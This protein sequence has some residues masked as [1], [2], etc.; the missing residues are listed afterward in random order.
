MTGY[1]GFVGSRLLKT[2]VSSN[3]SVI[4]LGRKPVR[5][6]PFYSAD[7]A[8]EFNCREVLTGVDVVIH[9]AARVHVMQDQ[10]NDP[11]SQYRKINVE[12]T[13]SLA[14]Q[15]AELD[16][17]RFVFLS[18]IKVNGDLTFLGRPFD[19]IVNRAPVDP[20]GLSKYEAE[21][22]LL[23]IA[24]KT[25]IEVVIIRPPLVYGPG[26]KGNF[27]SIVKLITKDFLLPLGSVSKNKRSLVALDNLVNFIL[28]CADYKRTPKAASQ[29]FVISD[30]EDVSTMELFQHIATAYGKK[31]RLFSFPLPLLR[32]GAML[33]SKQDV[34]DR[35]LG[36]L[37]V[38]SSKAR[39]L[40]GWKPVITMG[41][42]LKKMAEIGGYCK[43]TK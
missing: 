11:L 8:S 34:A 6:V 18:S 24:K 14:Q 19:E 4:L 12:A 27:E 38:N 42:Q 41:E 28:Y 33:L 10:E 23:E 37:Q 9:C 21:I 15:A 20:Y 30:G 43:K 32:L 5:D 7:L 2:L 39:N 25:G 1:T 36:S 13:L 16:V 26:V 40:L 3:S 31:S 22:G 35:L 29:T 17:K